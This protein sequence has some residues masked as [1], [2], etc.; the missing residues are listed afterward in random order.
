MSTSDHQARVETLGHNAQLLSQVEALDWESISAETPQH[1]DTDAPT[2]AK[3]CALDW[4]EPKP[5]GGELP[6]VQTF[7]LALLPYSLR[8]L[9][10]DTAERMQVPLDYPAV[11]TVL[12]LAGVTNR[13]AAIPPKAADTSWNVVPNLWGGIIA[14]PGLMKSPVI[15]AIT[16][17]LT[18]IE[19][20]WRAEYSTAETIYK[21]QQEESK[22]RHSAWQ[23]R[24]KAS[25]K[26]GL[27]APRRPVEEVVA[28]TCERLIT[29]DATFESLHALMS[30]N[31]AGIF[32]ILD[33]YT[34]WLAGLERPGREGER[35]FYLQ[36]WKWGFQ[37][38]HRP[39]RSRERTRRGW[40]CLHVGWHPASATAGISGRCTEGRAIQ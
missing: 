27:D 17:P 13:R 7:D 20:D 26:K 9:V 14:P 36:A 19:A 24:C 6:A 10:E 32:V 8:P 22:L 40:L 21:Q 39:H 31:P 12:C 29:Q 5:L 38:H 28:P 25:F 23:D 3:V 34:G 18:R 4:P 33:E 16:Q 11:A 30:E 37:L 2:E 1:S 35:A 15:S